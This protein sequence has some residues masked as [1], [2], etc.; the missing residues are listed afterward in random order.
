[1]ARGF[2]KFVQS[3]SFFNFSFVHWLI[4]SS[5]FL[6]S[7]DTMNEVVYVHACYYY[8]RR[9]ITVELAACGRVQVKVQ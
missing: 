6:L 2:C 3:L 1:M 8:T 4:V 9:E 5:S 7:F